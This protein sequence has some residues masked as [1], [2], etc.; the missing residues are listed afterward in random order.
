[1]HPVLFQLGGSPVYSYGIMTLISWL[2]AAGLL[3][4][5][6]RRLSVP[7]D[8]AARIV[9]ACLVGWLIGGRLGFVAVNVGHAPLE[10]LIFS[11]TGGMHQTALLGGVVALILAAVAVRRH[12]GTAFDLLAPSLVGAWA[13]ANVGCFLAGCCVGQASDAPWAM[14]FF[15]DSTPPE[16]R[17]VPVHPA[18]LYA[19][20]VELGVLALLFTWPPRFRGELALRAVSVLTAMRIA[21]SFCGISTR[22]GVLTALLSVVFLAAFVTL[23]ALRLDAARS[24]PAAP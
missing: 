23:V 20:A 7:V 17:G 1:M 21:F 12:V 18:Q 13:V 22:A 11:G 4:L 8:E 5:T 6:A 9:V 16:L 14:R 2:A 15:A 3:L 19:M 10:T 24:R